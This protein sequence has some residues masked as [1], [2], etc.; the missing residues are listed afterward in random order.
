M[1]SGWKI[2]IVP[3][4]LSAD[5]HPFFLEKANI[6]KPILIEDLFG[7]SASKTILEIGFGKGQF[8]RDYAQAHPEYHFIGIERFIQWV[9]HTE[10]RLVKGGAENVRLMCGLAQNV[11][12]EWFSDQVFDEIHVL[13]PDPW[14]KRRHH[15]H[16]ILQ[17]TY[18]ELFHQ[19]LKEGGELHITTDHKDY[20]ESAM[21]VFS[22][23]P[24]HLFQVHEK[25]DYPF[26]TNYQ[27]KYEKEGR[28][29]YFFQA[30]K[31]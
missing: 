24:K 11:L 30:H 9:R 6:P 14:P 29:I 28:P 13:F 31:I 3:K 7:K 12:R 10:K 27:I 4:M 17:K 16:R 8:V 5:P 19:K 21:Q 23:L 25:Q 1:K 20:F 26:K 15:K 2:I 18:L 22:T